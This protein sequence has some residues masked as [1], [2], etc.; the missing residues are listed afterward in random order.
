MPR[1]TDPG[2]PAAEAAP[3]E[4]LQ[5]PILAFVSGRRRTPADILSRLSQELPVSR[6]SVQ[7]AIRGLVADGELAYTYE[8]GRTFLEPSL[9]R[10]VRVGRRLIL[11][12]PGSAVS[13][14]REDVVIRIRPGVSFGVGRHPT[15]RLALRAIEAALDGLSTDADIPMGNVLDIGTGSG[16]LAV[17]AVKLGLAGGI[18]LDIDPCAVAEARENVRLNGLEGL[19]E[20]S[21]KAVEGIVRRFTLVAA[22][23]R[24]PTLVALAPQIGLLTEAKAAVV[25]SG[26]RTEEISS[27]ESALQ[28]SFLRKWSAIEDDWVGIVMR[29]R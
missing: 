2:K 18:G 24:L 1:P 6:G 23:L 25:V 20:V 22:N 21:D 16:V 17:A 10:A 12:P 8:F 4:G 14:E 27:I 26:I 11:A 13:P 7:A 28:E 3:F 15:T 19:I 9:D 29:K 5:G